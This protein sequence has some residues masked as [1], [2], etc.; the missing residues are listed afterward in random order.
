MPPVQATRERFFPDTVV[1]WLT[2]S[3]VMTAQCVRSKACPAGLEVDCDANDGQPTSDALPVRTTGGS[4]IYLKYYMF[5][6]LRFINHRQMS[7][8]PEQIMLLLLQL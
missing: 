1:Y 2:C 7:A 5:L 8:L 6:K 3:D 4:L